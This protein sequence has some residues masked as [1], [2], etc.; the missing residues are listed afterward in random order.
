METHH[1]MELI[2]TRDEFDELFCPVCGR[3]ILLRWPP[4]YEKIVVDVGDGFII[5]NFGKGGLDIGGI[6]VEQKDY[7]APFEEFL[8]EQ[9]DD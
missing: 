6:E 7:L 5:H 2:C 4:G 1:R 9:Q 3:R 8:D